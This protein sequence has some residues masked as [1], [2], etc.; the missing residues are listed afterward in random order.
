M[1]IPMKTL[2]NRIERRDLLKAFGFAGLVAGSLMDRRQAFANGGTPPRRLIL[3]YKPGGFFEEC[4]EPEQVPGNDVPH[5][6]V[7]FGKVRK[8][9]RQNVLDVL[10]DPKYASILG[11]VNVIDGVDMRSVAAQ[12]AH[13]NGIRAALRGRP[14]GE[15]DEG[16]FPG[17]SIDRVIGLHLFPDG[18]RPVHLKAANLNVGV[19]NFGN[20]ALIRDCSTGGTGIE[21]TSLSGVWDGLFKDFVPGAAG[22]APTG[23]SPALVDSNERRKILSGHSRAELESLKRMLGKDEQASLDRHLEAMNEIT[24]QLENDFKAASSG[25]ASVIRGDKLPG[26]PEK[27]YD[28]KRDLV[29]LTADIVNIIAHGFLFDRIRI[30]TLHT[31]GHN[32]GSS[33]WF[34]GSNGSYHGDVCHKGRLPDGK[35]QMFVMPAALSAGR[36]LIRMYLDMLLLLKSIPE[37]NGTLL[38]STT[39]ATFSDMSNGDHGFKMPTLFLAGGGGGLSGGKRVF[40]TGRYMKYSNR[41]HNDYLISLAHLMGVTDWKDAGGARKPL[42]QIGAARYNQGPLPG[43]AG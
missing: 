43:F 28:P 9:A 41:G 15:G 17:M 36:T 16:P 19:G 40:R 37:G 20:Q 14:N 35:G 31:F 12:D 29:P 5:G 4:F 8:G 18:G 30:A 2:G 6:M 26:R 21:T 13:H 11:D 1:K 34:P 25:G 39:V 38:D 42:T 24:R 10:E 23:P 32:N 7:T 22:T 33:F 3:F 27:N